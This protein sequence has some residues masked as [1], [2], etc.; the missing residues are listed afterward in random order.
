MAIFLFKR[1]LFLPIIFFIAYFFN[2]K[3][4]L[5]KELVLYFIIVFIFELVNYILGENIYFFLA[6]EGVHLFSFLICFI[7]LKTFKQK[8]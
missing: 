5:Q 2:R 1:F 8:R 3:N 7:F 6:A 4:N